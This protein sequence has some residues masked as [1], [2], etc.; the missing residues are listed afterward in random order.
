MSSRMI[1][2]KNLINFNLDTK[3]ICLSQFV[4]VKKIA[5]FSTHF[6]RNCH[7]QRD[8]NDEVNQSFDDNNE[9]PL[10]EQSTFR[11]NIQRGV[12]KTISE[13]NMRKKIKVEQPKMPRLTRVAILGAPNVGKSTLMNA[14]VGYKV[15]SISSK[16]HTTRHKIIGVTIEDETQVELLDTPGVVTQK[17][18]FKHKLE[19]TFMSDPLLSSDK[20][21]ILIVINDV[22]NILD[23]NRINP[24]VLNILKENQDKKSVLVLNKVDKMKEKRR[25]LEISTKLTDGIVGGIRSVT[26]KKDYHDPSK[27][28]VKKIIREN[29]KLLSP[30]ENQDD[31]DKTEQKSY[32]IEDDDNFA[33]EEGWPNFDRVFFLSALNH[34]G[35]NEVKKYLI[36]QSRFRNWIYHPTFVT[37]QSPYEIAKAIV[38]EKCLNLFS[39]EAPYNIR[40]KISNWDVDQVGNLNILMTIYCLKRHQ[41][42]IIGPKGRNIGYI[43]NETR[44]D[45]QNT[46]HCDVILKIAVKGVQTSLMK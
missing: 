13:Y 16:V 41:P 6:K 12:P 9:I 10:K 30:L 5:D 29:A 18:C 40:V 17:H 35:I 25:L 27:I 37:D 8:L 44:N 36:E 39:K 45:L 43:V 4:L 11:M 23:R 28:N 2:F 33:V 24:G 3:Y 19:P 31:K 7:A 38:L 32:Q 34:D 42:M 22:T 1:V 46:F 20:A 26:F 14:L 21:D 15:S